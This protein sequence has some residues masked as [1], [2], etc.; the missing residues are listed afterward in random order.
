MATAI[1]N[2]PTHEELPDSPKETWTPEGFRAVRRLICDWADRDELVWCIGEEGG[3]VYPHGTIGYNASNAVTDNPPRAIHIDVQ[4]FPAKLDKPAVNANRDAIIGVPSRRA[5]YEKAILT[6][7]YATA[8]WGYYK[9]SGYIFT[10]RLEPAGE[11]FT[12]THEGLYWGQ[13]SGT[14]LKAAEA[15]GVYTSMLAYTLTFHGVAASNGA[16][17]NAIS[18]MN[19][20]N[21]S[22]F[23]DGG[24]APGLPFFFLPETLYL[25]GPTFTRSFGIGNTLKW[26]M[27][28]RFLYTPQG[29]NKF[30]RA[31]TGQFEEIYNDDG[32]VRRAPTAPFRGL[33]PW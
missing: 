27:S 3:Q 7:T 4:P 17:G 20:C 11:H 25:V 30:W 18:L 6:V 22:N 14:E 29:W 12:T 9:T 15:P 5:D 13:S 19:Y 2:W 1:A 8:I 31:E 24:N 23:L 33:M 28:L 32:Q 26:D 16:L 21:S 10:A